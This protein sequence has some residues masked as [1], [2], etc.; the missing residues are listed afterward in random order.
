MEIVV[1]YIIFALATALTTLVRYYIPVLRQCR[2]Q[3]VRNAITENPLL[4][5]TVF[6]MVTSV[7]APVLVTTLL[8]PSH[9]YQFVEGLY[10]SMSDSDK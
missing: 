7:L 8:V 6:V 10:R 3:G 5:I 4:G 9:G 1:Y 2:L